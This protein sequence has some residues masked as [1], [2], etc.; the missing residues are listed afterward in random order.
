LV[1]VAGEAGAGYVDG[2]GE[3]EGVSAGR[4]GLSEL[5]Y[6]TASSAQA[7][8]AARPNNTMTVRREGR[9]DHLGLLGRAAGRRCSKQALLARASRAAR[10]RC[11]IASWW[12]RLR[13][14]A[15]P[16]QA[17]DSG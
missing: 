17:A 13:L 1:V 6:V 15:R 4:T 5:L 11:S 10:S 3:C 9:K 12:I 7:A 8:A 14:I 16:P 2:L